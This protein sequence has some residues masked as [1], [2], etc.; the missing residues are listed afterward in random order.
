MERTVFIRDDWYHVN[1]ENGDIVHVIAKTNIINNTN[2]MLIVNPD[3]LV[4]STTIADSFG[5]K[6]RAVLQDR[7]KA[8]GDISKPLI[9]GS[10]LHELFQKALIS[11]DFSDEFLL[12]SIDELLSQHIQQLYI[13]KEEVS[14][15]KDYLTSK[16]ELLKQWAKLFISVQPKVSRS[17]ASMFTAH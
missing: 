15:T 8:T 2:G 17:N 11:N 10:I 5:C 3:F 12:G 9:Y 1:V 7:V 4:S 6:R 16:F 13:L 14:V